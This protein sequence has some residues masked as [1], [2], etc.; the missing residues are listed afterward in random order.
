[1]YIHT[2]TN[3]HTHTQTHTHAHVHTHAHKHTHAHTHTHT[4]THIHTHH[5][6]MCAFTI[7]THTHKCTHTHTRTHTYTHTHTP[8]RTH[9]QVEENVVAEPTHRILWYVLVQFL[10]PP[11][12]ELTIR[13]RLILQVELGL[14]GLSFFFHF[15][16]LT[17]SIFFLS[18]T[19]H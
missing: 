8:I 16:P 2:H 17:N 1:M 10:P 7:H 5:K 11:S 6:H 19:H 4:N 18:R 3:M 13:A 12:H 15:F 14:D 9:P